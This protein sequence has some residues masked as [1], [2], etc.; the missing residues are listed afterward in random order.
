MEFQHA[1]PKKGLVK[2]RRLTSSLDRLPSVHTDDRRLSGHRWE[3]GHGEPADA[4]QL[5]MTGQR[6]VSRRFAAGVPVRLWPRPGDRWPTWPPPDICIILRP[7]SASAGPPFIY[8]F[9]FFSARLSQPLTPT[10]WSPSSPPLSV[11]PPPLLTPYARRRSP[12]TAAN[13]PWLLISSPAALSR[14]SLL[15]GQFSLNFVA[16]FLI[17]YTAVKV[18]MLA[19]KASNKEAEAVAAARILHPVIIIVLC[20]SVGGEGGRGVVI[21]TAHG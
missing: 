1:V 11:P 6:R 15:L 21:E 13:S 9:N 7:R 12:L 19:L 17:S 20:V 4:V 5:V 8:L 10:P 2:S 18:E 3:R 16:V 14:R